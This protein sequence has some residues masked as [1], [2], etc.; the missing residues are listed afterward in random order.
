MYEWSMSSI[1]VSMSIYFS[2]LTNN[3]FLLVLKTSVSPLPEKGVFHENFNIKDIRY[4]QQ[5]FH[6]KNFIRSDS[7]HI[8]LY[9]WKYKYI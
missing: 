6:C 2:L 7:R 9:L 4:Q 5:V 3:L 1:K 8:F